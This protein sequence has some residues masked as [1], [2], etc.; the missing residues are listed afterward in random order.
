MAAIRSRGPWPAAGTREISLGGGLTLQDATGRAKVD[1]HGLGF[2]LRYLSPGDTVFDV[3]A[4]I[5]IY[6]V[7]AGAIVGPE[8]R[9]EAFEPSPTLR[10]CL[11]ENLRRNGL[12]NVQV[13]ARLVSGRRMVDPFVDGHSL[14]GR[15]RIPARRDWTR[16]SNLLRIAS[17]QID[18]VLPNRPCAL[19]HI[20]VAG[21]ELSVL[22]GAEG[23]LSRPDAPPLLI[24]MDRA[25]ADY[26]QS[27]RRLVGWLSARRYDTY[28]YDGLYHLLIHAAEPWRLNRVVVALPED[29]R[30]R[31]LQ[32]LAQRSDSA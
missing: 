15:R 13:H 28:F 31:V 18:E 1:H 4:N 23:L 5:G 32:R 29:A 11:E 22:E 12:A 19:V 3:G 16:R 24:A 30:S 27:P 7:L 2:L 9:V 21:Y 14:T 26:G 8:G 25:L 6:S 20:D 10:P 17:V